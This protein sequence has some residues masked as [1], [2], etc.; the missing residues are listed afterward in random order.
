MTLAQNVLMYGI[1]LFSDNFVWMCVIQSLWL[2]V[3]LRWLGD[4]GNGREH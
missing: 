4:C 1:R 3:A 2:H